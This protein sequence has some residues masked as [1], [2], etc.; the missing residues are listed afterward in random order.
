MAMSHRAAKSGEVDRRAAVPRRRLGKTAP[1]QNAR[2]ASRSASGLRSL[3]GP[4]L[5]LQL[6][7]GD[8][9]S[10]SPEPPSVWREHSSSRV[11]PRV[12]LMRVTWAGMGEG[13]GGGLGDAAPGALTAAR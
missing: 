12:S 10:S 2:K 9:A 3:R 13:R 6:I 8:R 7:D 11:Q 1:R 4:F 5:H